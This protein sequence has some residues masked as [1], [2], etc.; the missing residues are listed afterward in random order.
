[1]VLLNQIGVCGFLGFISDVNYTT[2]ACCVVHRLFMCYACVVYIVVQ[3]ICKREVS[4]LSIY[5]S[6]CPFRYHLLELLKHRHSIPGH[7]S[8]SCIWC[9]LMVFVVYNNYVFLLLHTVLLR[10]VCGGDWQFCIFI[11]E[12]I[13]VVLQHKL[14]PG[15]VLQKWRLVPC[16]WGCRQTLLTLLFLLISS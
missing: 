3:Y 4:C 8:D 10:W 6:K 11:A 12:K 1:M 5:I 15:R 16:L 9:I 7:S 14:V 2:K 13:S